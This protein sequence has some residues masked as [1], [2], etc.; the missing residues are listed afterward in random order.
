[1]TSAPAAANR[2]R[3]SPR[4]RLLVAFLCALVLV[5]TMFFTA[6]TPL[7]PYYKHLAGLSKAG[8]G[9]RPAPGYLRFQP[10]TPLTWGN[11]R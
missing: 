11:T 2:P 5:D 3:L 4:L 6:L 9:I 10:S 7:L 8:A 1:M